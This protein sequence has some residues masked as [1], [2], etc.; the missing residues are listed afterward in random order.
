MR[1]SGPRRCSPWTLAGNWLRGLRSRSW[2]RCPARCGSWTVGRWA[3]RRGRARGGGAPRGGRGAAG[4]GQSAGGRCG[5][6]GL[7]AQRP[8]A[9]LGA[10]RPGCCA[11][12]PGCARRPGGCG[13]PSG[14]CAG[15]TGPGR[16]AGP[17]DWRVPR[18]GTGDERRGPA[19]NRGKLGERGALAEC[20]GVT[21]TFGRFVAVD[22][23]D[24]RLGGGEVVGLLG[25]NGAGK[26]TL[27]RMLLGLLPVSASEIRLFGEPPSRGT[28]QRIGYLPQ[29]LG[30][31]DDLTAA[32]NLAFSAAVF[33]EGTSRAL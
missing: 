12:R 4:H 17:G 16:S 22:T 25:A 23:V 33:G 20:A 29:D 26:T 10:G 28:R 24:L 14:G 32:E 2:R 8:L 6:P 27:I 21:G 7:A 30:L 11:G 3:M 15:R 19:M 1:R 13:W 31:Y 5:G 9:G 18:P